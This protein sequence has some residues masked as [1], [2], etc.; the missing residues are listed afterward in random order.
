MN[1]RTNVRKGGA[2][3]LS[4]VFLAL[5]ALSAV[6]LAALAASTG[7]L[8][9][10][11]LAVVIGVLALTLLLVLPF[12]LG[13]GSGSKV[14]GAVLSLILT[15][16]FAFGS[17]YLW[18]ISH[19]VDTIARETAESDAFVV[20]V[21]TEDPAQTIVDAADYEFAL[22]MSGD[23]EALA[24][25]VENISTSAGKEIL[26]RGYETP[27]EEA[28]AL[29]A[30]E[31]PAAI[32]NEAYTATLEEAIEGYGDRVR[33]LY[34]AVIEKE[35]EEPD[36]V[37]SVDQPF[38]VYISGIDVAGAITTTSRSDVNIIM[39]I[40]PYTHHIL[41]TTTPRDYFVTIPGISGDVRDKLTHAGVYGIRASM[42][43]LEQLYGIDLDYYVRVNFTSLINI[44]D[45]LG[46]IDVD[47]AVAFTKGD[48]TFVQGMNHMDGEMAL[49]FSR[50]RYAFGSGDNQ[51]GK[52]QE[53]VL[54]AI[55]HKITSPAVLAHA[56]EVIEVVSSCTQ[57]SISRDDIAKLVSRQLAEGA[58]W[59]VESQ[60]AS[61]TGDSQP[62]YSMGATK[63]YVMWP[64]EEVIQELAARMKSVMEE[65]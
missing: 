64:D 15:A 25:A 8:P 50:E 52:N 19:A 38:T 21:R 20:V 60:A 34:R 63:L 31:I 37:V 12:H 29:L 11:F 45:A 3:T 59:N 43:T 39:T 47:S 42:A 6:I 56:G 2:G 10:K 40:N 26:T 24:Q 35:K 33:I 14:G 28:E 65:K 7:F 55:I 1:D 58:S 17:F 61:G 5:H 30:E 32:Y 36:R 53:A 49:A 22:P 57:T 4:K 48:Y 13:K 23:S 41:L 46:G 9:G 44:V 16:M 18:T 51:R 54:T 27:M 62:T